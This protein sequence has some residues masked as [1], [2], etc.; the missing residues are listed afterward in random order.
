MEAPAFL[1]QKFEKWSFFT[2]QY[3]FGTATP[4]CVETAA[5]SESRMFGDFI[6]GLLLE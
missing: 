6:F 4:C 5:A 2:W 1:P 3:R